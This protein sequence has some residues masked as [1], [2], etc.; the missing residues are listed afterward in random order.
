MIKFIVYRWRMER[1][2]LRIA[3][4][5]L[6][7]ISRTH[8]VRVCL[9]VKLQRVCSNPRHDVSEFSFGRPLPRSDELT[10]LDGLVWLES[11]R[12]LH[13]YQSQS[14]TGR[15]KPSVRKNPYI[16]VRRSLALFAHLD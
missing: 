13:G 15:G 8:L 7:A 11:G 3:A 9:I 12:R 1:H 14:V 16:I 4:A 5:M 6:T 2:P 10:K